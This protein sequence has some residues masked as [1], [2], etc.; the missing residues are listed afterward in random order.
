MRFTCFLTLAT[1][2]ILSYFC[3]VPVKFEI[4][5]LPWDNYYS[6]LC[7]ETSVPCRAL[8]TFHFLSCK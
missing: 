8:G 5:V 3:V 2:L 4:I 6:P 1:T 7:Q